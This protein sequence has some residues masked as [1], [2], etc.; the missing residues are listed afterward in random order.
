MMSYPIKPVSL[1]EPLPPEIT[2]E[3]RFV[4]AGAAFYDLG[5]RAGTIDY[6][7]ILL[8]KMT[9]LAFSSTVEPL[10]LANQLTG[11]C[12]YRWFLLSEDGGPIL[13]SNSISI[14]VDSALLPVRRQ[15]AIIVCS[16]HDGYQAAGPKTL[17]MLRLHYRKGGQVGGVCTGAY[18]LARA[19]LLEGKSFTM[20]WDNQPAFIERFPDLA[21]S[22]HIFK[23]DG[24]IITC[25]GGAAG[26]DMMLS[27]IETHHGHGLAQLVTDM[28]VHGTQRQADVGQQ[29]S[30]ATA[31]NSRNQRLIKLVRQMHD[32]IEE[33]LSFD[34]LTAL[35]GISKR[36]MERLFQR[37]L[38]VSP[39]Q[40]YKNIRVD[41]GR[42]LIAETDMSITEIAFA[43]GFTSQSNF[44]R[45]YKQRF[46]NNPST[47]IG[48][49]RR[50]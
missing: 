27:A 8:P 36:Q 46:G 28:C 31:I 26:T 30:I 35:A 23:K 5:Y 49:V 43:C 17:D 4:P 7:F 20:H 19:G 37:Y 29:S 44:S 45:A 16:G 48:T 13:C 50:R 3:S 39:A 33:P 9:M 25:G 2:D 40:Y 41:Y 11:Q 1:P 15:D 6:Y 38:D 47:S 24:N 14:N 34:E 12:L 22:T 21:V 32:N 10:R 42:N 18:T